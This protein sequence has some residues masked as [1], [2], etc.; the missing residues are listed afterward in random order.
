MN[1]D[2]RWDKQKRDVLICEFNGDWTWH[3]CR[4]AMQVVL[5]MQEGFGMAVDL[6][7][8][9]T[10]SNLKT[11][12]CVKR[13]QKLLS[14]SLHPA[15]KHIVIVDNDIRSHMLEGMLRHITE[16]IGVEFTTSVEQARRILY[17]AA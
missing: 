13:I 7:Y 9:F 14:M 3:E 16:P 6:V 15:P 4:E 1:I 11:R 5:Y 2:I 12:P 17:N 8:D 10:N